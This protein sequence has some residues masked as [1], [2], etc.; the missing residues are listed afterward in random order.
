[1]AVP[2]CPLGDGDSAA[3]PGWSLGALH[4][5]GPL[6]F[7]EQRTGLFFSGDHVLPRISPNVSSTHR[8]E[9]HPL[10]SFLDSLTGVRDL[11]PTEVL[12]AHEWRFRGLAD[13]VDALTAHHEARLTE[14]LA[15][16]RA[17]PGSTPWDLAAHLTWSRPWEACERRMRIFAATETDATC[18]CWPAA[19]WS[20]AAAMRLARGLARGGASL[21][22]EWHAWRRTEAAH[23]AA[24][25]TRARAVVVVDGGA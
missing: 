8:G 16:I 22:G 4:T 25:D 7:A 15:A 14:F 9:P 5:P 23:F 6:C 21:A 19:D 13:R 20:W 12:P 1:M 3:F 10:R 2:D 17:H 18:D 11:D 24:D